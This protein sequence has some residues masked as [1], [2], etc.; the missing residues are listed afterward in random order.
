MTTETEYPEDDAALAA[1]YVLGLLSDE[2]L[3]AFELR[4]VSERNLRDLVEAWQVHFS[5][6]AEEV[7]ERAPPASVW[8]AIEARL[9]T[10]EQP[11]WRRL[12]V[13]RAFL[14]AA[15]A[16][17]FALAVVQLGWLEPEPV[18]PLTAELASETQG[19]VA[20]IELDPDTGR[21]A[22]ELIALFPEEGRARE[23]WLIQGENA[24][25]S[26]GLLAPGQV[27]ALTVPD[28]LRPALAGALLAISDE[29]EGGSP[30]GQP[31]GAVLAA[32]P[33]TAS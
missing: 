18:A 13:G 2:E 32:G 29:P 5:D 9:F 33:I 24:P 20:R 25:V 17:L 7:P 11:F 21:V 31:T 28:A 10:Q 19:P 8:K 6:L 4:L 30:T 3:R 14:G 26:L 12:L 27:V 23:L 1:E 22:A 16:G 15:L